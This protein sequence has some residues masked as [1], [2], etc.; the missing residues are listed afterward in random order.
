ME[1]GVGTIH[2]VSV[3]RGGVP[4]LPVGRARVDAL[5]LEGDGHNDMKHHGG[6]E[7][8]VCLYSL[9]LLEKLNAEGHPAFPGSMG[10]N[11]TIS[12]IAWEQLTPGSRL[13]VGA[14]LLL[15]ISAYTTPCQNIAGSFADGRFVR[16]S[17]K[18][19]PGESRLYARVLEVGEARSGD[20]VRLLP[21]A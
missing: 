8:A 18:L 19:H 13:R 6:P 3:S 4:K 1:Q 16:L 12:G 17:H 7:R 10:E 2:Q 9:E 20:E 15:Q 14:D 21:D 5:G 11:L